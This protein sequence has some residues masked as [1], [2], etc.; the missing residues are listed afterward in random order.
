M[1]IIKGII[2]LI[3]AVALTIGCFWIID[4]YPNIF[5]QNNTVDKTTVDVDSDLTERIYGL[6]KE[7]SDDALEDYETGVN[8]EVSAYVQ[9]HSGSSS[10]SGGSYYYADDEGDW[11]GGGGG[12]GGSSGGGYWVSGND[13][14]TEYNYCQDCHRWYE[15]LGSCPYPDCPSNQY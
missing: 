13:D 6:G 3:L 11:S 9:A 14:E 12:S 7:V 5:H 4:S 2:L 8:K 1:R 10:G 15:G